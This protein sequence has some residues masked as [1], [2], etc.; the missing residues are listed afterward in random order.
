MFFEIKVKN[1]IFKQTK[2]KLLVLRDNTDI[3]R[4]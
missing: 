2:A 1:V 3:I 4:S